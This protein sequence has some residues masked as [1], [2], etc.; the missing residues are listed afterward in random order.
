M[1]FG[2]GKLEGWGYP[3]AK[4]FEDMY[5]RLESMPAYDRRTDRQTDKHLATA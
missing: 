3:M 5:N 4:I 1:P 2:V